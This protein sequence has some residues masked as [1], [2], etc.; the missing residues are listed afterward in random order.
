M[1]DA[2]PY[3]PYTVKK[4]TEL[5]QLAFSGWRVQRVQAGGA[6]LIS[7]ADGRRQGE[8]G[9]LNDWEVGET[10]ETV[11]RNMADVTRPAHVN[12]AVVVR[13]TAKYVFVRNEWG[14]ECKYHRATGRTIGYDGMGLTHRIQHYYDAVPPQSV[15][16]ALERGVTFK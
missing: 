12:Y 10:V 1:R 14:N 4:A 6:I 5:S 13:K 15:V 3:F 7:L 11:S 8:G 9:L 16:R 2:S